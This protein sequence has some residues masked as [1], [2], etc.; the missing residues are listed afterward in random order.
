MSSKGKGKTVG[1]KRKGSWK[2]RKSFPKK[3]R[4]GAKPT[5]ARF[6]A[7]RQVGL[8]DRIMVKL[9]YNGFYTPATID[10]AA[11]FA[12]YEEFAGNDLFDPWVTGTGHQ[13][14]LYDQLSAL[15]FNF[16]VRASSIDLD[17]AMSSAQGF[18]LITVV[19]T[20]GY[21]LS[22]AAGTAAASGIAAVEQDY[23]KHVLV[24]LQNGAAHIHHYMSTEKLYGL[25]KN[26][27]DSSIYQGTTG[28]SPT[29]LWYWCVAQQ[30]P[31]QTTSTTVEYGNLGASAASWFVKI[32]YYTEFFNRNFVAGS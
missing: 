21:V 7:G 1:W 19:P 25:R 31:R 23:E 16:R 26:E 11:T 24:Q 4:F 18:S 13:P 20:P 3:R 6:G 14:R 17:A 29:A 15:Y 28:S 30:G 12:S 10:D 2:G 27:G 32:V 8:P 9:A 5:I 22:T